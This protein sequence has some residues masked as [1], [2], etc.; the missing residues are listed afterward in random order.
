[1]NRVVWS[2]TLDS[3]SLIEPLLTEMKDVQEVL[4][5]IELR[6]L[7]SE[8]VTNAIQHAN[9]L[10]E[11]KKVTIE[12]CRGEMAP[13]SIDEQ[14]R[15]NTW[16]FS[17]QD[18]GEGFELEEVPVPCELPGGRGVFILKELTKFVCYRNEEKRLIFVI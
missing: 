5:A 16:I 6:L 11:Q 15:S 18:E 10:Q 2:S 3:L 1:M 17:I 9:Q 12:W 4:S 13:W 7:L 8:A 14:F